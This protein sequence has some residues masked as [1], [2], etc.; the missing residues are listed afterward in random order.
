[1]ESVAV[2][3]V[4][5]VRVTGEIDLGSRDLVWSELLLWLDSAESGLVADLTGVTF[6]AAAGV[7]LLAEVA[8][9]AER[10][11]VGFALVAEHSTVLSPL[12]LT[13]VD[14][15]IAIH[16]DVDRAVA[17]LRHTVTWQEAGRRN[18]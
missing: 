17:A 6:M 11:G 3:D 4:Q 7:H 9:H 1:M 14:S 15:T 12:R 13:K 2:G 10:R 5:V 18:G 16:P 8:G